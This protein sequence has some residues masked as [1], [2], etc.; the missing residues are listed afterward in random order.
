MAR[1]KPTHASPVTHLA[2]IAVAA[3]QVVAHR[4]ARMAL[5]GPTL[6]E[7]DRREFTGM[8][9]E[10]QQAFAQAWV[11]MFGEAWRVQQQMMLSSWASLFKV[12]PPNDLWHGGK[13]MAELQRAASS[14]ASAGLAPVSKKAKANARRLR[15]TPLK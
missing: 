6:S 5:A 1:R 4:V 14:I 12:G 3:P 7:R 2:D 13:H 11:A 8:V 9:L 15:K 10:K